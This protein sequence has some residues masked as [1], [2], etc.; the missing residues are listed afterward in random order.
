MKYIALTNKIPDNNQRNEI[1]RTLCSRYPSIRRGTLARSLCGRS[2]EYLQIGAQHGETV[3][4]A[5]AFHGME[6]ITSLLLFRFAEQLGMAI[7]TGEKISD[8]DIG[9]FCGAEAL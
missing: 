7:E 4:F 5:G 8:I 9:F 2:M 3:L 6:W 1:L